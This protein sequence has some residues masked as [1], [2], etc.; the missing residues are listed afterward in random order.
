MKNT[1]KTEIF[2]S[3]MSLN[4]AF[5]AST[6]LLVCGI[7]IALPTILGILYAN[8][9]ENLQFLIFPIPMVLIFFS[10]W[11]T[12]PRSITLSRKL[13]QIERPIGSLKFKISE[14]AKVEKILVLQ[15]YV[16]FALRLWGSGGAWGNFGYFWSRKLGIFKLYLT[17]NNFVLVEMKNGKKI[18]VSPDKRDKFIE[19]IKKL[20]NKK[21]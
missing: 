11:L 21:K 3:K 7:G 17:N 9:F 12:S 19:K 1:N 18:F 15:D 10:V 8:I 14:I 20:I 6:Y 13:L 4:W 16:G 2:Y 5:K